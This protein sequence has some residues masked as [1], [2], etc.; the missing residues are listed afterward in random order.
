MG[1]PNIISAPEAKAIFDLV[2]E[3]LQYGYVASLKDEYSRKTHENIQS[4]IH[5]PR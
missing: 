1:D 4:S 2:G 3:A 5:I